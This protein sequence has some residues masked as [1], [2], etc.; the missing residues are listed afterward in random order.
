MFE[1]MLNLFDDYIN[2]E[3]WTELGMKFEAD[4]T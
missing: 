1:I 2:S 4:Y 3:M